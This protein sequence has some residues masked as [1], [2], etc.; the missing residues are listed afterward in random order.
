[1]VVVKTI[2]F[3]LPTS[4]CVSKVSCDHGSSAWPS[5]KKATE[6][7]AS[8]SRQ[9]SCGRIM[10]TRCRL[11]MKRDGC[12]TVGVKCCKPAAHLDLRSSGMR[13]C[14]S[15]TTQSNVTFCPRIVGCSD[16][17]S[18]NSSIKRR[19]RNANEARVA[20]QM[21]KTLRNLS[22]I[23]DPSKDRFCILNSIGCTAFMDSWQG[24]VVKRGED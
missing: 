1:M 22:S 14:W 21:R 17:Q 20:K 11:A 19:R 13:C 2:L 18:A 8:F 16:A 23:T 6:V 3:I 15:F 10:P 9:R 12:L 5:G 4:S 24:I 7:T